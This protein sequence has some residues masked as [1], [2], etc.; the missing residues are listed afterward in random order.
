MNALTAVDWQR[1]HFLGKLLLKLPFVTQSSFVLQRPDS[2]DREQ[3]EQCV[4][5]KFS[6]SYGARIQQFLP[7]LLGLMS[8]ANKI[9]AVVGIRPAES[10]PL[11]LEQYLPYP[12]E[13]Q[14]G[15]LYHDVVARHD[16]VEL[17]NLVSAWRGS[18]HMIFLY[19]AALLGRTKREWMVFTSTRE[20]EKLLAKLNYTPVVLGDADPEKLLG[21]REIWGSYYEH[22][23]RVMLGHVPTAMAIMQQDP[24]AREILEYFGP[25]L[26]VLAAGFPV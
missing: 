24:Y 1:P 9:S 19:L 7:Y 18:S 17:G 15:L 10:G 22:T 8:Q 26:D 2:P 21:P 23:P 4:S 6:E 20:V 13:Q 5:E 12:I 14:I 3:F 11:F 25:S 16:I